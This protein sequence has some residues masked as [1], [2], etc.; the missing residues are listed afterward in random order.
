M[1]IHRNG[2]IQTWQMQHTARGV[3]LLAAMFPSGSIFVERCGQDSSIESFRTFEDMVKHYSDIYPELRYE[4]F[5]LRT[6]GV[7]IDD[8]EGEHGTLAAL[9]VVML[10]EVAILEWTTPPQVHSFYTDYDT[11]AQVTGQGMGAKVV[12]HKE[13]KEHHGR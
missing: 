7:H 3:V 10:S 5:S 4:P 6:F 1:Y 2:P 13:Q 12:T 9:G 8:G 11:M